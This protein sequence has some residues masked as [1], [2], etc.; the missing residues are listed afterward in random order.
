VY[1]NGKYYGHADEFSNFAQ[2]VLLPP[3]EYEVKVEPTGSGQAFSRKVSIVANQI[4]V[5]RADK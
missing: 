2:G 1:I 3:G 5:V 4:V